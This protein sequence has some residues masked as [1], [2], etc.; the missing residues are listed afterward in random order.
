MEEAQRLTCM[1]RLGAHAWPLGAA[2]PFEGGATVLLAALQH[3][4]DLRTNHSHALPE[5]LNKLRHPC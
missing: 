1:L 3:V 2:R 5:L 4:L